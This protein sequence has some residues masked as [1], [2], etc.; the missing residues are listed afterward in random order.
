MAVP[1]P[2]SGADL[3]AALLDAAQPPPLGRVQHQVPADRD[4]DRGGY[5]EDTHIPGH[6]KQQDETDDDASNRELHA[7]RHFAS[8]WPRTWAPGRWP[9]PSA[10]PGL[11]CKR[12]AS[13]L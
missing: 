2:R 8:S 12:W 7:T 11:L 3:P 5:D 13:S 1:F 6:H 10:H 9:V 4:G